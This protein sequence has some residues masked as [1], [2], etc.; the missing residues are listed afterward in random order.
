[1]KAVIIDDMELARRALFADLESYCPEIEVIGEAESVVSGIKLLKKAIPDIVFLDI[2]LNDGD[3][4]D[5]LEIIPEIG[6]KVIFTTA[7]ND[8]A[9][10]AF[11]FSAVDYLLKPIDPELLQSAVRKVQDKLSIDIT[12]VETLKKN[13]DQPT[14]LALHT[15]E[16]IKV[17]DFQEII[18]LEA[19][20]NYT[21][22]FFTDQSKLLITKTLKEY[23][24]ILRGQNFL[25]VHQSHLIN[26]SHLKAYIK[27]EGGYLLMDDNSRVPVSVRKKAQVIQAIDGYA[28]SSK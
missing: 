11:R 20:G 2:H 14:K 1:M 7:S 19:M 24:L 10:Q 9:I 25:R 18:R 6:S 26:M 17:V 23:D 12:Q 16:V 28:G 13:I 8:H 21:T 22:F 27:S 15:A 5:I 4:F 3:G